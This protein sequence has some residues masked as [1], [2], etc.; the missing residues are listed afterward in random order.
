[1]SVVRYISGSL[2][3]RAVF[4]CKSRPPTPRLSVPWQWFR[5]R[6]TQDPASPMRWF[7]WDCHLSHAEAWG[8]HWQFTSG[9]LRD[10]ACLSVHNILC[11][12]SAAGRNAS[13]RVLAFIAASG[14]VQ[15]AIKCSR[16]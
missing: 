1:M 14:C 7:V 2:K 16:M 15:E 13:W 5:Q 9:A 10:R 12:V 11:M 4:I 6:D 8:Q 3:V